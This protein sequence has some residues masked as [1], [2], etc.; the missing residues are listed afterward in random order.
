MKYRILLQHSHSQ[1][2]S[3]GHDLPGK[4]DVSPTACASPHEE[5]GGDLALPDRAGEQEGYDGTGQEERG[6]LSCCL[7]WSRLSSWKD[8][9]PRKDRL[10]CFSRA[11]SSVL[12]TLILEEKRWSSLLAGDRGAYWRHYS[13]VWGCRTQLLSGLQNRHISKGRH[14]SQG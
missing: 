7:L 5:R 3:D 1:H 4:A 13:D 6:S 10:L 11:A 8:N 14:Q 2:G 9:E 12:L